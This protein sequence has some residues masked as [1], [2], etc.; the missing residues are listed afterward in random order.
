MNWKACLFAV[1]IFAALG[2]AQ[3]SQDRIAAL[4]PEDLARGKKIYNGQCALCHGIDGVGGRGPALTRAKLDRGAKNEELFKVILEGIPGSE[5]PEFWMLTESEIWQVAGYV[6]SL[7]RVAA[8]RLP[9]DPARGRKLY[10]ERGNCA[11][12]HIVRG[13]GGVAGPDLTEIGLRRSPAYL[14]EALLAPAAT[15]PDGYLVVAV[16]TTDGRRVRG[17]RLNEDSFSIQLRDAGLRFHSFRK[18]DLKSLQKEFGASTMP[19]YKDAFSDGELDDLVA[20][21][22]SL[23]GQQ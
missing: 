6:R 7:G 23:R 3:A 18:S 1:F 15:L 12:C 4:T 17:V 22:Y 21:L 10:E 13:E 5:M 9:G 16:T 14:R 19:G 11:A 20:Y 8:V 2:A